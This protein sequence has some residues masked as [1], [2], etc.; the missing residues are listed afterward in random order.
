MSLLGK[1][2]IVRTQSKRRQCHTEDDNTV[3]KFFP[4]EKK[5]NTLKDGDKMGKMGQNKNTNRHSHSL[6]EIRPKFGVFLSA[7]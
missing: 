3:H 5:I 2:V 4:V 7:S 6:P 1:S